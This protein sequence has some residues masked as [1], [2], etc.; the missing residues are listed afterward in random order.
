MNDEP[1]ET[2]FLQYSDL[3]REDSRGLRGYSQRSPPPDPPFG[4]CRSAWSLNRTSPQA[5]EGL[6]ERRLA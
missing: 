4:R 3:V 5:P 1:L 2:S 6:E